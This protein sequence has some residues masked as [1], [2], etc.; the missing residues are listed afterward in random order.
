MPL[1]RLAA[2]GL[3]ASAVAVSAQQPASSPSPNFEFFRARVQPVFTTKRPGNARCVTCH[4]FGTTMQLQR[5]LPGSATWN[6]EQS[7]RNFEIVRSRVVP[8][9]PAASRLLRHPLAESAGGDPHLERL[10]DEGG[11]VVLVEDGARGKDRG[12]AGHETLF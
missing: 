1:V 4:T 5:L 8:G 3:L 2:A 10:L 11:A 7:R 9:N 12:D 6:E